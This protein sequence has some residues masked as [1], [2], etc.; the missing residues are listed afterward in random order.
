MHN[1]FNPNDTESDIY[2]TTLKISAP[3]CQFCDKK[4]DNGFIIVDG[5]LFCKNCGFEIHNSKVEML[6][7]GPIPYKE[8]YEVIERY[9]P[10]E[11][12]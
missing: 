6:G 4:I 11:I 9:D 7:G 8:K 1:P 5:H 2:N 10:T 3:P 12:A